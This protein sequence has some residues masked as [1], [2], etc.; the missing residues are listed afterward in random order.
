M[1]GIGV[2]AGDHIHIRQTPEQ[3]GSLQ[4][5][6]TA[7]TPR[8][9]AQLWRTRQRPAQTPAYPEQPN[10]CPPAARAA[11]QCHPGAQIREVEGC[12]TFTVCEQAMPVLQTTA[13]RRQ[14][15][16]F[17]AVLK[18][19][20]LLAATER[21]WHHLAVLASSKIARFIMDG[22]NAQN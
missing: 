15:P 21:M 22:D 14:T 1:F 12:E 5:A 13:C 17:S 9:A 4:G 20:C 6:P 8:Q 3:P 7:P 11:R 2:Y 16:V 19:M 10:C 18:P